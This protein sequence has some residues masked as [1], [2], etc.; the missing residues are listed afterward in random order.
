MN[1]FIYLCIDP[2]PEESGFVVCTKDEIIEFGKTDNKTI[3]KKTGFN[4]VIIEY[5]DSV[6][7]RVGHSILKTCFEI[8]RFYEAFKSKMI[9]RIGRKEALSHFKLKNDKEVRKFLSEKNIKL[10]NDS[11][12]AYFIFEYYKSQNA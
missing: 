5:P 12:Q 2:G 11:W 3:R 4:E 6:H 7:G 9:H 8:G 10:V 1:N